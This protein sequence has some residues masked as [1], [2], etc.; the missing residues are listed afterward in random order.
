MFEYNFFNSASRI[1]VRYLP[2]RRRRPYRR[3]N[4]WK[5]LQTHRLQVASAK[6]DGV[7]Q[8]RLIDLQILVSDKSDVIAVVFG[9]NPT[10]LLERATER[11]ITKINH[12]HDARGETNALRNSP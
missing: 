9:R 8:R 7:K 6:L 4:G 11:C 2:R 12:E 1:E 5:A 3:S 10:F